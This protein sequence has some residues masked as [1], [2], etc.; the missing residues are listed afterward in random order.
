MKKLIVY[1]AM[2]LVMAGSIA[3]STYAQSRNRSVNVTISSDVMVND[4]LIKKGDYRARVNFE[5]GELTLL[6]KGE[7]IATVKGQVVERNMKSR[8]TAISLKETEKGRKLTGL[9]L[10]GDKRALVLNDFSTTTTTAEEQ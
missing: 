5:T 9:M 10:E 6:D 1:M 7:V 3:Y 8:Y 4:T 2:A